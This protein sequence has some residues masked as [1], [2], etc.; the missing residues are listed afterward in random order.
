MGEA[1]VHLTRKNLSQNQRQALR[2]RLDE[3]EAAIRAL[4]TP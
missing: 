2:G 1:R 3:M 4:R